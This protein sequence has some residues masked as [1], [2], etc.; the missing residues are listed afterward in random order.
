MTTDSLQWRPTASR[1]RL[2][3]RAEL[4]AQ[5]RHFFAQRAVMEVDTPILQR[6][7]APDLHIDPI[8]CEHAGLPSL[9]GEGGQ[10]GYLHTS[11][12]TAMKR[13]LAAGSGDIYYL[14]KVF[15]LEEHG[16][17]HNGEF[18][19]LEWYRVG[20]SLEQLQQEVLQLV[21]QTLELPG[22]DLASASMSY[23]EAFEQAGLSNP[24][25]SDLARLL[26]DCQRLQLT[27]PGGLSRLEL[28]DWLQLERVEPLLAK[29]SGPVLIH[30]FP[31]ERA[32]MACVSPGPPST[33]LRFELY[34]R[35]V[36]L[37]NGY[38]ELTDAAEQRRRLQK[39]NGERLQLGRAALPVDEAFLAAMEAGLPSM[40]G[41]ALGVDRLLMIKCDVATIAEVL[42][43]AGHVA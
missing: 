34:Y 30:S 7:V 8:C 36:E 31:P 33:A 39:A 12:E 32:A 26:E 37:A 43:F 35:G 6:A 28:L 29:L 27:P 10:A 40:S 5:L 16:P 41:V 11:P 18:T 15:R 21:E 2:I 22:A 17:R 4:L 23:A 20:W 1:Q 38:Q 19:M 25:T 9:H 3:Q 24:L 13:L 42:P 14:G